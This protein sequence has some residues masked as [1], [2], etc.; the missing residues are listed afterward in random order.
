MPTSFHRK[1][2]LLKLE[3]GVEFGDATYD[4]SSVVMEDK[5]NQNNQIMSTSIF[6]EI[7]DNGKSAC[8]I[9]TPE[10]VESYRKYFVKNEEDSKKTSSVTFSECKTNKEI[11]EIGSKSIEKQNNITICHL[12]ATS[13]EEEEKKLKKVKKWTKQMWS[14]TPTNGLFITVWPGTPVKHSFIGIAIN[15]CKDL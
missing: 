4:V 2:V 14:N 11:I 12:D 7:E 15:K 8:L 1:L 6:K 10:V 5:K 3:K 9:S 13:I